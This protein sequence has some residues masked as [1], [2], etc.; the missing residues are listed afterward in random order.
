VPLQPNR[1]AGGYPAAGPGRPP[2]APRPSGFTK[3][4]KIMAGV[5]AVGIA[6]VVV[7]PI[8]FGG[9]K[10]AL[11][12][13][14]EQS[15]LTPATVSSVTN[16][17]FGL[18]TSKDDNSSDD[19]SDPGCMAGTDVLSA[20]KDKGSASRSF[21]SPDQSSFIEEDLS[22]NPANAKQLEL[23]RNALQT[24]HSSTFGGLTV[25]LSLGSAPAI[26]GASD[27]LSMV[28]T[29]GANGRELTIDFAIARFGDNVVVVVSGSAETAG[30]DLTPATTALLT[31]AVLQARPAFSKS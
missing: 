8:A 12:K 19:N 27:T 18:D 5:V 30:S 24:C 6:A 4:W 15:L 29:G 20:P 16:Q 21:V 22:N 3:G 31:E 26:Q 1:L 23:L 28:M 11:T 14:F 10:S 17:T 2:W 13:S 7:I 25:Q 9:H